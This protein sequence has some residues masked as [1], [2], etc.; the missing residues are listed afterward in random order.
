MATLHVTEHCC[1]MLFFMFV[2][3]LRNQK[4]YSVPEIRAGSHWLYCHVW[5]FYL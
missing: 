4:R 3:I 2:I 5:N 1:Q